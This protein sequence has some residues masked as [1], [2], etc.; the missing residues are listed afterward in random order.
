MSKLYSNSP[1]KPNDS[2][3][4]Y[5]VDEV[6][7]CLKYTFQK[8]KADSPFQSIDE[9]IAKFKGKSVMKQTVH[10]NETDKERNKIWERC[11]SETGYT[12]D[13]NV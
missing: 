9:S 3:K 2:S 12:Y 6:T 4:T 13:L 7:T 5:Y 8:C 10:A 11:D 1:Q